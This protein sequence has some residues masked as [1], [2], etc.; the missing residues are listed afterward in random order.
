MM[1]TKVVTVAAFVFI[2]SVSL[3]R[4]TYFPESDIFWG[5]RN[6]MDILRN[7]VQIFQPDT[8]N[9]LTLGEEWSPNSWLW[10]V[11]LGG[12]YQLF[13]D[14]GFLLLT[15]LT[16][17]AAYSFL[18]GYLQKLRM[19]PLTAFPVLIGCWFIMN[20]F[21]NGRSNTADFLILTAF[22]Y[23][24]RQSLDKTPRLLITSFLL[25]VLW[26]NLH[27]TGI[28][29]VIVFP[30]VVYAMKHKEELRRRVLQTSLVLLS[31]LVALLITPYGL[32]GLIK[33][34]MVKNESKGLITEWSNV[35]YLPGANAGILFLLG[36]SLVWMVFVFKKKQYLYGLLMV[37]FIYSTYDTIRLTPFLLTVALGSLIF[38]EGKSFDSSKLPS[39]LQKVGN[40]SGQLSLLLIFATLLVSVFSGISLGRAVGDSQSMFPVTTDEL[41]LIPANARAAVLQDAGSAIILY[42]PDVLVTLDG[43]NDLIGAE[44][45]VEASNILYSDDPVEVK[46]WLDEH[47]IDTVFIEDGD[48]AGADIIQSN[49]RQ[50][51]WDVRTNETGAVAFVQP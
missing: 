39:R 7:G 9:L 28:A 15:L 3:I 27:L 10:N 46:S 36:A 48:A 24:S 8:W 41:S 49:M 21:M 22:L 12:A 37:A 33:V 26:M 51:K 34:S 16:N 31:T 50:L 30:A 14:Y 45:F 38:W 5:A 25:T 47:G 19:A 13:G 18:W 4:A 20:M 35:F 2:V 42:R 17:V 43:R 32:N 6:G 44:R 23:L 11:L 29:A 1:K 40:F